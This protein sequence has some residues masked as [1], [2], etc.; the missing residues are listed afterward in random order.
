MSVSGALRHGIIHKKKF[1]IHGKNVI[2]FCK[3]PLAM[4]VH[5]GKFHSEKFECGLCGFETTDLQTL[6]T[7][8]FTCDIN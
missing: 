5:L 3:K 1:I 7:P 4:E 8:L 2:F 6:E